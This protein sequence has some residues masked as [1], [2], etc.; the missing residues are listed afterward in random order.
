VLAGFLAQR[1]QF[2]HV[3]ALVVDVRS[4][5]LRLAAQA[6]EVPVLPGAA[7]LTDWAYLQFIRLS[8]ADPLGEYVEAVARENAARV[9]A[10]TPVGWCS[11]YHYY[12]R[13]TEA[14]VLRNLDA[15]AQL[16]ERLPLDFVQLDDGFQ[17][18]VGDWFETKPT[19]P[20]GLAWLSEQIRA[21]DCTPGL[22]LAPYIVR[23]D[24]KLNDQHPEWFLRDAGGRRVNAGFNW[25]RWCFALDPTHPGVRAHVRRLIET[26]VTEW[27][28]PYLKLD[29]LYA[30]ALPGRR[31]DPTL[32]RAQAMR[33]ALADL[34]AA[35]GDETFLL[36]CGCPLGPAVGV[37]DGM[38]I[39]TDVAPN[40]NPEFLTPAFS[41]WVEAELGFVSA[42]NAIQNILTREPFHRRWWLN[43]PDCLLVRDEATRLNEVE[44]RCLA[45]VIALSSG[46]FLIS[47]D[48]TRLNSERYRYITTL[49]PVLR[50]PERVRAPDWLAERTPDLLFRPVRS[51]AGE[52]LVVGIFHWGALPRSRVVDLAMLGLPPGPYW[53]ANF[54]ENVVIRL[55]PDEPL[56]FPNMPAH[57]AQLVAL[58]PATAGP[59][60]V[61]SAF[62]FSQG[63]EVTAWEAAPG[64]LRFQI[65]LGRVAEGEV[66]LALP[67]P[68][69]CVEV[70]S[71]AVAAVPAGQGLYSLAFAVNG[72]AWVEVEW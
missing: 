65:T 64:R 50:T 12:D 31:Y 6:D 56:R 47:D 35:A 9:P 38:R 27:G 2:G 39:S 48:L 18:Q 63:G 59:A 49:L 8:A 23:S 19:F 1:E 70:D 43:D 46:M 69:R 36:G 21:R 11:W 7:R 13:V 10:H 61:A 32:T 22:W 54:W 68:P 72:S 66:Q 55:E 44:V 57:S 15:I 14:A 3:E 40:W 71:L 29:F 16:R 30:A 25:L 60:L 28:F 34:R 42:R 51:P 45:T 5:F 58:R 41:S 67:R 24:A 4:P 52:W 37:V 26:A 33:L 62:H 53:V 17:A 20:H